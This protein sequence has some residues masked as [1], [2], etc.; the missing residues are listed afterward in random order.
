MTCLASK[1]HKSNGHMTCLVYG[2]PSNN[3]H[4]SMYVIYVLWYVLCHYQIYVYGL[5]VRFSLLGIR[6]I[7]FCF[8]C[9]KIAFSGGKVRGS[10]EIVYRWWMESRSRAL[11]DSRMLSCFTFYGFTCIFRIFYVTL[12][13]LSYFCFKDNGY[14]YPTYF[15]K[16]TFVSTSF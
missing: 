14:P 6:L 16:V 3:G 15:M 8:M 1:P 4:Y 7:P 5:C 2:T 10:L 9:R 11:F 13:T 12:F